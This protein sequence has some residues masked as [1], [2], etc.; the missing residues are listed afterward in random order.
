V[1]VD[2]CRLGLLVVA[3]TPITVVVKMT[4]DGATLL[5]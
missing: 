2:L 1:A 5:F 3:G 4:N